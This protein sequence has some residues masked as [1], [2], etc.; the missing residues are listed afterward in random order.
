[1]A[2]TKSKG[3]RTTHPDYDRYAVKWKRCRDVIAGQ[4]AIHAA[5]TEYLDKLTDQRDEDYQAYKRR[6]SFFNASWRTIQGFQGMLYRKDPALKVPAGVEPY[7]ADITMSGVTF[8]GFAKAVSFEV[9]A[10]GRVGV[11][12]DHPTR[13]DGVTGITQQVSAKLGLRPMMQSYPAESIINWHYERIDNQT[14][15]SLLVL[16]ETVRERSTDS[17]FESDM[18]DQYR[19]LDLAAVGNGRAYRQRVFR[20]E[21]DKDIQIGG[22]L[23][24]KI[25][26][27]PL[28]RIPFKCI[29]PD[30]EEMTLDDPPLIDLI[31]LNIDHYRTNADYK[32]GAHFT[33]LPMLFLAGVDLGADKVYVGSQAAIIA[34]DPNADGKYIEFTGQGLGALEKMLDREERQMAVLGARMLADEKS[35]V[36][37]LGATAIKRTGENSVLSSVAISLSEALR[38]QLELF[39]RWGGFPGEVVFD[40]N[41]EFLP[42]QMDAQQLGALMSAWQAGAISEPEL[43]DLLKRGDVIAGDKTLEEHQAEI[44]ISAPPMPAPAPTRPTEQAA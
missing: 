41:R 1:M 24:P 7:L 35:Q 28:D 23:Y 34:P 6:A 22:D 25:A 18:V 40:I 26:G 20:I 10:V 15:L 38:A 16:K 21:K 29:G 9:L 19:V 13:P 31:N 42:A 2:V 32:N 3:V 36:E 4:D 11:L 17:E 39:A 37:T 12:V 43:F 30:G 44:E 33:G 5:G 27:V 14:V 8:L